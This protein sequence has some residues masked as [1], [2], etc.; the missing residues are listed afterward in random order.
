MSVHLRRA[1]PLVSFERSLVTVLLA[2]LIVTIAQ[3]SA[4][5]AQP[6]SG[7][8]ITFTG[9]VPMNAYLVESPGPNGTT[10]LDVWEVHNG[11]TITAY[12]ID[13]TKIMHMIV[14]SDDLTE[15]EHVHP[16]LGSDGHLTID[17]ALPQRPGGYHIYIDGRPHSVGRQVFRFDLPSPIAAVARVPHAAGNSV[18]VGPYTVQISPTKIP[19]GEIAT[20]SV[21]ILKNG[22]PAN[23]LHP[24]LGVMAHGVFIGTKDLAYMHAHGMSEAMLDM[25]SNDCGDSMM[26]A[27]TPMPPSLNIGNTFDIEIIAPTTQPYNFWLQ[28][29]GGKTVYTAPFLVTTI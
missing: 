5:A 22:R 10:H 29:V 26:A 11:H 15:F 6:I 16:K 1:A 17:L 2:A 27:M 7:K 19:I 20:V 23:D 18:T 14:V 9:L 21:T 4:V 3:K 25:A 24:Y 13:M 12:D 8:D 28:F